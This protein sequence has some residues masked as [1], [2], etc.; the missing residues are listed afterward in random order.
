MSEILGSLNLTAAGFLLLQDPDEARLANEYRRRFG[1][2]YGVDRLPPLFSPDATIRQALGEAP[3]QDLPLA[4]AIEEWLDA[5]FGNTAFIPGR[6]QALRL[7]NV[8]RG[9]GLRLELVYCHLAWKVGQEGRLNA[10]SAADESSPV[11][12]LTYGFDVSW[13]RCNHSAILQPPV[14]TSTM[15]W[16]KKLNEYGLLNDYAD[17]VKL[18]D[19]Y[20]LAYPYPPFDI[21][22][23]HKLEL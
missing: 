15:A 7:F 19:D 4:R 13:P 2:Y 1:R 21:Y 14:V 3:V 17:A 10:Y 8:L 9:F 20:L 18:R 5:R 23:V 11:I 12:S 22:L 16:R 6:S